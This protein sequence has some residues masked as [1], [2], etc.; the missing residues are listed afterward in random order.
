MPPAGRHPSPCHVLAPRASPTPCVS[1]AWSADGY[2]IV[3][4]DN[5]DFLKEL[6]QK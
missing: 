5:E 2:K 1:T 6:E 4:V 3:L